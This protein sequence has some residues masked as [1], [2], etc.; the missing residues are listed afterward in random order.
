MPQVSSHMK[1]HTLHLDVGLQKIRI[2]TAK[3]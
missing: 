1:Q 3:C 2:K